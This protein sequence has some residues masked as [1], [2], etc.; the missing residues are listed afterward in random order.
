ML[1]AVDPKHTNYTLVNPFKDAF[2]KAAKTLESGNK[3]VPQQWSPY[4]DNGGTVISKSIHSFKQETSY[5][6]SFFQR[7]S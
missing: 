3:Q 1:T 6:P 2:E 5:F 4:D 7:N